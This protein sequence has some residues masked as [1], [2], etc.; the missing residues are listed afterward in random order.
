M[1]YI[2]IVGGRS[3]WRIL[4][5]RRKLRDN[6]LRFLEDSLSTSKMIQVNGWI[7]FVIRELDGRTIVMGFLYKSSS[8]SEL[9]RISHNVTTK[10]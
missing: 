3:F 1:H 9:Y 7:K 10:Y 2:G 4:L 5:R 8:S 6:D